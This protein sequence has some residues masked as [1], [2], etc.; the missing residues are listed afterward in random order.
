MTSLFKAARSVA[1]HRFYYLRENR[2]FAVGPI[3]ATRFPQNNSLLMKNISQQDKQL[4][5]EAF[6]DILSGLLPDA[7][8]RC[9]IWQPPEESFFINC[10][11]DVV[12]FTM[13]DGNSTPRATSL[14]SMREE[15]A[16]QLAIV[17]FGVS[18]CIQ[19]GLF[20]PMWRVEQILLCAPIE[21]QILPC[22]LEVVARKRCVSETNE[23]DD[24]E[25]LSP[26]PPQ[27]KK[28]ILSKVVAQDEEDEIEETIL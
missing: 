1:Q 7:Q 26:P 19:G 15:F 17:L 3:R 28:L 20:K 21:P 14:S 18:E 13:T 22:L 24:K 11:G 8:K 4:F 16:A 27:K 12:T 9:N 10:P 2:H 5:E 25:E 6:L 23:D